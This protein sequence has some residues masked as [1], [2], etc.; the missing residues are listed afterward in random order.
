MVNQL[1]TTV[2]ENTERIRKL[3]GANE[4]AAKLTD[5]LDNSKNINTAELSSTIIGIT[6]EF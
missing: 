6:K 5:Y 2:T 4:T 3:E 1:K